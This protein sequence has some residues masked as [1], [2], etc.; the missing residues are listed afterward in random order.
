NTQQK[1]ELTYVERVTYDGG[2]CRYVYPLLCP[3]GPKTT[4]ADEFEFKWRMSSAVPIKDVTC[5]THAADVTRQAEQAAEVK[6]AGRQVD[7]SKDLE[8][9]YRIERAAS[10]MDL[11][12]HRP[13]EEDGTFMLLLTPQANPTPRP[14]DMTFVFDTSGSMEGNRIKQAKAALKFCISKLKPQ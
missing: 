12:A 1:I 13:K 8:V 3:G 9:H 14:K 11:V 7:L 4:K 5:P 6:F 10:G 2:S